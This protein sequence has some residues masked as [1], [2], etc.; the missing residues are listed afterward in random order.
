MSL[1]N[2]VILQCHIPLVYL[3]NPACCSLSLSFYIYIYIYIYIRSELLDKWS[4][5][6][7]AFKYKKPGSLW[8]W[9]VFFFLFFFFI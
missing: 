8:V 6:L 5:I 4:E 3:F 7:Y 1:I 9:L 2:C